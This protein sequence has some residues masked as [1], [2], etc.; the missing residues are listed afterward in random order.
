[1]FRILVNK[2]TCYIW[3]PDM[4]KKVEVDWFSRDRIKNL[5]F[6]PS[7]GGLE[8]FINAFDYWVVKE[9]NIED[10]KK[11]KLLISRLQGEAAIMGE[12]LVIENDKITVQDVT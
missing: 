1:M 9:K 2:V 3:L 8:E 6:D 10:E 7:V 12:K 11:V 5:N 4:A